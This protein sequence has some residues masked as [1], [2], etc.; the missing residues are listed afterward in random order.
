MTINKTGLI[1][2]EIVTMLATPA[3]KL[4]TRKCFGKKIKVK[5]IRFGRFSRNLDFTE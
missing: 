4:M 3:G 5:R 1:K 2:L